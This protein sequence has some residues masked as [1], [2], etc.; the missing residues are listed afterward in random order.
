MVRLAQVP[1]PAS[2]P[3]HSSPLFQQ[4]MPQAQARCFVPGWIYAGEM[5]DF[6]WR[7]LANPG[8]PPFQNDSGPL[9]DDRP[10]DGDTP[11]CEIAAARAGRRGGR[12]DAI[13][14]GFEI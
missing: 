13:V 11:S 14:L 5:F 10:S 9:K 12:R 1:R 2:P 8:Q 6:S 4:G 3:P 7:R